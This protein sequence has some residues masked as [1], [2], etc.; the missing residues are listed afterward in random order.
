VTYNKII[1]MFV[2]RFDDATENPQA[3]HTNKSGLLNTG[4]ILTKL[5][6]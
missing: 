5:T 2:G 4:I 6:L 1:D 3:K